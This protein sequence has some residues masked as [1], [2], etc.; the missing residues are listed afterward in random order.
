MAGI[1]FPEQAYHMIRINQIKISIFEAGTDREQEAHLV[2]KAAAA[3]I[4]CSTEDI[5]KLRI[6]R[7]SIDARE[8][9]NILF[10]YTV[11]VR[12]HDSIVGPSAKTEAAFVEKLR[13]RDILQVTG[14]PL[15]LPAPL[16]KERAMSADYHPP[17]IAGSGPC[18]LFAAYVLAEC[19]Y[20]PI[21][22]ERGEDVDA[23]TVKTERF[24][25]TGKLDPDCNIQFGE[26]GAGTFSDGKLNTSIKDRGGFIEFVLRTFVR[27]GADP[28]ILIDQKPHVGT[29][30]LVEIVRNMRKYIE[31]KGGEYRFHSRLDGILTDET[32]AL[33][34]VRYT[35]TK[36]GKASELPCSKLI[37][38]TGHSA[39]DTYY[40][41]KEAGLE[42]SAKPFAAGIRIQHPQDLIDRALYGEDRLSEKQAILGPAAYKL[43]HRAENGRSCYSFCMCPGGYVVN[44]SSEEGRLCVNGMSYH[45]RASGTAN[46]ALIVNIEPADYYAYTGS[47]DVLSGIEFQRRLEEKAYEACGGVIPYETYAEFREKNPG[48]QGITGFRSMYLGYAA[49]ADVR[50]LLPDYIGDAIADSIPAF[51]KTIEGY[52]SEDA[53]IAGVEARTSSPVRI[54][55]GEDRQANIPGIYPA[56]EGAGYAGGITSAAADGIKTALAI[57]GEH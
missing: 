23:R 48:P 32:G 17:V 30:V 25:E 44:S 28:D 40:M 9:D 38:A 50:G 29:D 1:D 51:A 5:R 8:K 2:K 36:S 49:A 20:R 57:I 34:A 21:L 18:G 43:T 6:L 35:D 56:G 19:G 39:R 3:A 27:F 11:N 42:L 41:L 7:R 52:D 24:F 4:G 53:V 10:V 55:R 33:S 16:P 45:D 14:T 54:L 26:G 22:L 12:L 15:V 46:S 47:E 37:L 13:N 31:E